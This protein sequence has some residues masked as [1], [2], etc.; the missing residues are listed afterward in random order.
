[1]SRI[2]RRID[3]NRQVPRKEI[4]TLLN[5]LHECFSQLYKQLSSQK[6]KNK[7]IHSES[8]DEEYISLS[9]FF[10]QNKICTPNTI[11]RLLSMDEKF[12]EMCGKFESR[13]YY[14][15]PNAAL[16]YLALYGSDRMKRRVHEFLVREQGKNLPPCGLC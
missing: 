2:I 8:C 7:C 16:N 9:D 6:I 10:L 12:F 1:M 15:K 14:I 3:E 13:K 5:Y 4:E 11:G